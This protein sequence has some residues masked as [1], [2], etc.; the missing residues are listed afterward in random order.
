MLANAFRRAWPAGLLGT[1]SHQL[2]TSALYSVQIVVP[3]LGDSISD[4]AVRP[5]WLCL[6]QI[7]SSTCSQHGHT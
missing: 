2:Q 1:V 6:L 7:Q 3:A 4:G 5:C